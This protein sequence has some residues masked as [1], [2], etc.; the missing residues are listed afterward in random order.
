MKR[1]IKD[2]N[3][4]SLEL[5]QLKVIDDLQEE[6]KIL[7]TEITKLNKDKLDL[8]IIINIKEDT[9]QRLKE[10]IHLKELFKVDSRR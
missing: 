1:K 5:H 2:N 9:N 8:K 7:K 6:I 4:T 10:I 3:F